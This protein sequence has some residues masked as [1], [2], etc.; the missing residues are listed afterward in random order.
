AR[1]GLRTPLRVLDQLRSVP[2]EVHF[3]LLRADATNRTLGT[4]VAGR[5]GGLRSRRGLR[6]LATLVLLV[7]SLSRLAPDAVG[8]DANLTLVP[9][10]TGLRLGTVLAVFDELGN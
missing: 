8:T 3:L 1:L 6:G 2:R 10:D 5:R 7:S 9:L 4:G